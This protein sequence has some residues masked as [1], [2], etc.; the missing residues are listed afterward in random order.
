MSTESS[1]AVLP[2]EHALAESIN[3]RLAASGRSSTCS[4]R[5]PH[6]TASPPPPRL[7]ASQIFPSLSHREMPPPFLSKLCLQTKSPALPSALVP[8][9]CQWRWVGGRVVVLLGCPPRRRPQP[10]FACRCQKLPTTRPARAS[11][12]PTAAA[13]DE[14]NGHTLGAR[15]GRLVPPYCRHR[16]LHRVRPSLSLD[17]RVEARRR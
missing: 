9:G 11:A 6:S 10:A 5:S 17:L 15:H 2:D 3:R 8:V 13:A 12:T 7:R 1:P 14:T 4:T 16:Q